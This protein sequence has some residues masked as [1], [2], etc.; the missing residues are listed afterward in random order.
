MGMKAR[1]SN[2]DKDHSHPEAKELDGGSILLELQ[3]DPIDADPE[4]EVEVDVAVSN[5]FLSL[6]LAAYL[7]VVIIAVSAVPSL[8]YQHR[9]RQC[10]KFFEMSTLSGAQ[11]CLT[12]FWLFCTTFH[13]FQ[14]HIGDKVLLK[15]YAWN[16]WVSS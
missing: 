3:L 16:R 2:V 15:A 4:G 7:L 6:A 1:S 12:L 9:T 5:R 11:W 13:I 14:R 10:H 8:M